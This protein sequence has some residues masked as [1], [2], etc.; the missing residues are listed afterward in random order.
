MALPKIGMRPCLMTKRR[1]NML[2]Q[3]AI[4]SYAVVMTFVLLFCL[5]AKIFALKQTPSE[6]KRDTTYINEIIRDTIYPPTKVIVEWKYDTI[7]QESLNGDT[8]YIPVTLPFEQKE[9][10]SDNYS[11][12]ISGYKPKLERI[13]L[14]TTTR[15]ITETITKL[16]PPKWQIGASAGMY[17]A[18]G[19]FGKYIGVSGEY[20]IGR[21]NLSATV[22]YDP[23]VHNPYAQ[24]GATFYIFRK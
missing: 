19:C 14:K 5:G 22:G 6:P 12:L 4:I 20:N 3:A 18:P 10:S 17:V 21:L 2:L 11:L 16:K 24:A 9:Y 1:I 7:K 8:V 15:T 23:F 13:D